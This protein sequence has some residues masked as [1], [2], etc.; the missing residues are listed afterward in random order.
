MIYLS[1]FGACFLAATVVPFSSEIIFAAA[2]QQE[3]INVLLLLLVASLGNTFGGLTGYALG[4]LGKWQSLAK[5]F[6]IK[7]DKI[8]GYENQVKKYGYAIALCCWLPFVGDL[9]AVA[10]GF[11]RLRFWPCAALMFVGKATRYAVLAYLLT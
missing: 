5:Y 11:F 9:L 6:R 1:V 7:E 10:L 4:K 2:L 8:I 3:N